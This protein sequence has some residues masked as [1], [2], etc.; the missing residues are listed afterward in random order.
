MAS[1]KYRIPMRGNSADEPTI[2]SSELAISEFHWIF[3][4]NL[5]VIFLKH[6]MDGAPLTAK[7]VGGEY[8]L[9]TT[10]YAFEDTTIYS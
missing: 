6:N 3:E 8:R 2:L 4:K 1:H 5:N 7:G 9:V 10:I